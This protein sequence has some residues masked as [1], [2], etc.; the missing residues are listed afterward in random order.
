MTTWVEDVE[1][2][3]NLRSVKTCTLEERLCGVIFIFDD[4]KTK[5][6]SGVVNACTNPKNADECHS[7]QIAKDDKVI[8]FEGFARDNR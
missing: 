6:K 8:S 3:C 2:A 5:F 7:A 4:C 1:P